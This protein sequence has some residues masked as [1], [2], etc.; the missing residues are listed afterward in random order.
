MNSGTV[1]TNMEESAYMDNHGRDILMGGYDSSLV[2]L[3]GMPSGSF[4]TIEQLAEA[5]GR[6]TRTVRRYTKPQ[7]P[8]RPA[9]LPPVKYWKGRF[10]WLVEDIVAHVRG[11]KPETVASAA[12]GE[13]AQA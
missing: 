13:D 9:S 12:H 11:A 8:R 7:S 3:M 5:L 4:V 6:S 2:K 10:G 1:D